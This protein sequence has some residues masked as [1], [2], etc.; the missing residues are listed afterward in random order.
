MNKKIILKKGK[1]ASIVRKHPWVFSGAI[2]KMDN[3][4]ANG[5]IVQV[6]DF[7]NAILGFGHYQ[8][9]GSI[10]VRM[11]QFG[12]EE[13]S[14]NLFEE[15]FQKAFDLRKDLGIINKETNCYRLIHGEGD[16]LPGL[17]IDIYDKCALYVK[18]Y[19]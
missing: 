15:K 7:K 12:E 4:I 10:S 16:N 1:E 5:E 8:M 2:Q 3:G 11:L 18:K 9:V 19:H 6:I 13:F 14:E 17:I